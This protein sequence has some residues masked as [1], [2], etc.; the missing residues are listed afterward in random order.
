MGRP[1]RKVKTPAKPSTQTTGTSAKTPTD[2]ALAAA[3]L[4]CRRQLT[5]PHAV[6]AL[7][8]TKSALLKI[9]TNRLRVSILLT[10]ASMD[11]FG[12]LTTLITMGF[13]STSRV[14]K[15]LS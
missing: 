10:S 11:A 7:L 13:P 9:Q 4:V 5:L 2:H 1:A 8:S 12:E 6:R 3:P 15:K 14:A